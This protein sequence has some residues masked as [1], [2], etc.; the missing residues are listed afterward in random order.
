MRI[1][2]RKIN[3]NIGGYTR[4][5]N[6]WNRSEF[7]LE[8]NLF[9][10][11]FVSHTERNYIFVQNFINI[12]HNSG[13][14]RSSTCHSFSLGQDPFFN[15]LSITSVWTILPITLLSLCAN[16][17]KS[18]TLWNVTYQNWKIHLIS[19]G[20]GELLL[21]STTFTSSILSSCLVIHNPQ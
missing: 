21:P 7:H 9:E 13:H 8:K 17:N 4:Q 16:N 20:G 15:S 2:D 14:C 12:L 19:Q 5:R 3:R 10:F 18:A 1:Q 6:K 11:L